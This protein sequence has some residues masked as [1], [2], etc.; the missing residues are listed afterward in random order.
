MFFHICLTLGRVKMLPKLSQS[1][2]KN[3]STLKERR[4]GK[5]SDK[6]PECKASFGRT[7]DKSREIN[8]A[9]V[10][11]A[12]ILIHPQFNFEFFTF[13][14][15]PGEIVKLIMDYTVAGKRK[16]DVG[17]YSRRKLDQICE[18]IQRRKFLTL[19]NTITVSLFN[20]ILFNRM[21][22]GKN[23]NIF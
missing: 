8:L 9:K 22:L 4:I 19:I 21:E 11:I 6:S 1:L 5:F 2:Q 17:F 12:K 18:G 16:L 14:T 23:T 15:L 20:T 3:W 7:F 10:K 13:S